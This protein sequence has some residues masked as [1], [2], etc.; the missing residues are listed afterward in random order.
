MSYPV[1]PAFRPVRL[2]QHFVVHTGRGGGADSARELCLSG[3]PMTR[4]QFR[5]RQRMAIAGRRHTTQV[6]RPNVPP[7]HH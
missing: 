1:G 5:F 2:G 4:L 3:V 6:W 7:T